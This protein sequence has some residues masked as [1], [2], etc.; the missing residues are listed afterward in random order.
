M[1]NGMYWLKGPWPGRLAIAARPRGGEWLEG[2]VRSWHDQ[3]ISTVVSLL[4]PEEEQELQLESE[5]RSVTSQGIKFVAVP[6]QDRGVP[7]AK[8]PL[9]TALREADAALAAGRNV[10]VH[11][12]QGIGRSG[13]FAACLLI[14]HDW[15]SQKAAEELTNVRGVTV[16]ETAEQ[17]RWLDRY[18][19]RAHAVNTFADANQKA[20]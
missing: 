1:S 3:A 13:L 19:A 7:D 4:T 14:N 5:K 15:S 9:Q 16:P 2:E 10:L 12:R 18:E 17:R 11:C 8:A 6:V 20:V